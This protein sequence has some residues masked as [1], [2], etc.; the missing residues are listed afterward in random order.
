V[1]GLAMVT[2]AASVTSSADRSGALSRRRFLQGSVGT[3]GLT[4]ASEVLAAS[5]TW[6]PAGLAALR[7]EAS[8]L[9]LVSLVVLHRGAPVLAYGDSA[10]PCVVHSMRKALIS[11]LY[12]QEIAKGVINPAATIG[13]LGIEDDLGL[14]E[15]EKSA[16]IVDLLGARS[17]VYLPLAQGL[18]VDP[19]RPGRGQYRP[20]T[21]WYYSNWDF[22]VLG[23]LYE[24][25]THKDFFVAFEHNLARP[26]GLR[27]FDIFRDSDYVYQNDVLGGNL[28]YPNYRI[29][30]S[31]RDQATIGQLYLQNG[32]WEGRQ[33]VPADWVA[34]S[35]QAHS[36]T[37]RPG[38]FGGYGYLWWVGA[39]DAPGTERV[40]MVASAVG[41]RGHII[42]VIHDLET[43]VV[44]QP[45]T[46]N[47]PTHPV[48]Q[49]QYERLLALVAAAHP[50]SPI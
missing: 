4:A 35:T 25:L 44:V 13:S 20:G 17:G 2:N 39:P 22:N 23:N 9:E 34:A 38:V 15:V 33:L 14:T 24:R 29:S 3:V 6:R 42:G 36:Q 5:R 1:I 32:R 49:E 31:A 11:A 48:S 21:H 19:Q 10:K 18:A 30:L 50:V 41:A 7:R 45:D 47:A 46:M 28:R 26:L 16:T 43:V 8:D 27:D 37:D 40:G 12:G